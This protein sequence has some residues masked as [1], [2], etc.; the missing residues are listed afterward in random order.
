MNIEN[1]YHACELDVNSF[2]ILINNCESN[3][4]LGPH[5]N[6]PTI[7]RRPERRR[8]RPP[9]LGALET[10]NNNQEMSRLLVRVTGQQIVRP[11]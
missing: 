4:G 6:S 8:A 9:T 1:S 5:E 7:G 10:P 2:Y 3:D 11:G